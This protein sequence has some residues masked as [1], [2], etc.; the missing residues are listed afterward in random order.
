MTDLRYKE[1]NR[2]VRDKFRTMATFPVSVK[3]WEIC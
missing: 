1:D 2:K 3:C